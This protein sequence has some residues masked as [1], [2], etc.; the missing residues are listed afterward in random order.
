MD[1]SWL[2]VAPSLV[3]NAGRGL[4]AAVDLPA[5]TRL[6]TYPGVLFP[7]AAAWAADKGATTPA[8]KA[9]VWSLASGK[10]IDPTDAA[11]DV[12]DELTVWGLGRWPV[13]SRLARIN[14]PPPSGGGDV[15]VFADEDGDE[16]TFVVER[17]VARGSE[18]YMDYGRSYSRTSYNDGG[19]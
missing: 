12:P 17:P 8:A 11:G 6:G 4:F 3:P 13:D 5:G 18:L 16:V 15:N 9:F 7:S 1:P 10:L 2:A 19:G 14:E